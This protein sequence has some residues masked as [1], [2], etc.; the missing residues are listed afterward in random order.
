MRN[1]ALVAFA[2][3]A[4]ALTNVEKP[5]QYF[6]ELTGTDSATGFVKEIVQVY[7]DGVKSAVLW[8]QF[9]TTCNGCTF[10]KGNVIQNWLQMEGSE[11]GKFTG[12]TCNAGY[13]PDKEYLEN[14][15]VINKTNWISFDEVKTHW[16]DRE[17]TTD[18]ENGKWWN[19]MTND[20]EEV[21]KTTYKKNKISTQGCGAWAPLYQVDADGNY[22]GTDNAVLGTRGDGAAMDEMYWKM[23][24]AG[25]AQMW[26]G[27][28]LWTDD[29]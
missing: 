10:A 24:N 29:G 6:P 26:S 17:G 15:S 20:I 28:K 13:Q 1:F 12:F 9:T 16:E 22:S 18:G 3:V 4:S 5:A 11:P 25:S 8:A 27:F 23:K 7:D 21:Y 14:P 2:A 19:A